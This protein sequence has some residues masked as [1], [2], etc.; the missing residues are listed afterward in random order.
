MPLIILFLFLGL[1]AC[2]QQNSTELE[3]YHSEKYG[4]T[5][6]KPKSW[7]ISIPPDSL[8]LD[9]VGFQQVAENND[10]S[11]LAHIDIVIE[12]TKHDQLK[13]FVKQTINNAKDY[14]ENFELISQN[15]F[16]NGSLKGENF[17]FTSSFGDMHF[18]S[19]VFAYYINGKIY[20]IT[21]ESDSQD[22]QELEMLFETIGK[23]FEIK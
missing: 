13:D 16:K 10:T 9:A 11:I 22:F 20:I 8:K 14:F 6:D 12:E 1:Q 7:A 5:I 19:S 4:F 2:S 18:K 17:V 3:I 23:S 21:A 15:E